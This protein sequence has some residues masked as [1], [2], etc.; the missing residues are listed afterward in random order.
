MSSEPL[1]TVSVRLYSILRQRDGRIVDRLELELPLGS[2]VSGVLRMLDVP[3]DLELV[4][5]LNDQVTTK[6]AILQDRDRLSIIP[7][8]AGGSGS[9]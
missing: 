8:V 9:V 5:A 6:S 1:I 2:R 7:A 4:L 3:Q